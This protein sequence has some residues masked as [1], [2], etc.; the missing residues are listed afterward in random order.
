MHTIEYLTNPD[1]RGLY[2]PSVV[3]GLGIALLCALLSVLVVLKRLAF[4]G[5]G[6]SHA[7]LGGV[8]VAAMVGVLGATTPGGYVA[9]FLIVLGVCFGAGQL[10]AQMTSS[11]GDQ[12]DAAGEADTAIGVVLVASMS[13]GAIL[14]HVSSR[15][16]R[17]VVSWES[18]LFGSIL[19]LGWIDACVALGVAALTIVTLWWV[20]RPLLYWAFDPVAARA[21]GI[22]DR[23]M[24]MLL[25]TLLSLATVTAMKLAGVVLATAMLVLPGAIA[26]KLSRRW[27][28]VLVLSVAA[29]LAGV[30]GGLIVSFELDWLPGASIVT[31]L[32]VLFFGAWLVQRFAGARST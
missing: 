27:G 14:L 28:L 11:A 4:I 31:V 32:S 6:I 2:W 9:Q 7:A 5:Q 25:L 16:S 23:A 8:G 24:R 17:T 21:T 26:L 22:R 12:S 1:L 13:L 30:L 3:A 15:T 20:R 18:F 10:I 29:A 19:D